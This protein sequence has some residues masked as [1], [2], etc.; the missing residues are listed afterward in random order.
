VDVRAVL[1]EVAG[2]GAYFAVGTD[3]APLATDGE[4]AGWRPVGELYTD[5]Q[6][7]RERIAQVRRVLDS[8]GRVAASIAFQGLAAQL[9]SAPFAAVVLHRVLPTLTAE[10]LFWRPA[11]SGPWPLRCPNPAGVVVVGVE[12]G[13][14]ALA[15]LLVAEH[16]SSLIGAVRAQ[17]PV[18]ERLLWGNVASALAGAKRLLAIERPGAA[19]RAAQVAQRL[20]ATG[21]LAGTGKLLPPSEPDREWSF[22]RR[23]CCLYYRA[24]GGGLCEDCVL[25]DRG[26]P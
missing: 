18:G 24:P 16:L 21:P 7:L 6:P 13:A 4:R 8:D 14:A 22:R 2:L 19:Q 12:E 26:S 5:P 17:V 9:V 25:L 3:P 1:A 11:P 15:E 23:S 10:S 20:L